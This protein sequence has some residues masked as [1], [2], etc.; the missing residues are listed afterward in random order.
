MSEFW[1]SFYGPTPTG[2][3]GSSFWDTFYGD[4]EEESEEEKRYKERIRRMAESA[5]PPEPRDPIA[6]LNQYTTEKAY[7]GARESLEPHPEAHFPDFKEPEE[8]SRPDYAPELGPTFLTNSEGPV[9]QLGQAMQ[10]AWSEVSQKLQQHQQQAMAPEPRMAQMTQPPIE[11]EVSSTALGPDQFRLKDY[12]RGQT[13]LEQYGEVPEGRVTHG[14]S[15]SDPFYRDPQSLGFAGHAI[16]AANVELIRTLEGIT[17]I[18]TRMVEVG[19]AWGK[20]SLEEA[21]QGNF[22]TTEPGKAAWA[23]L[24]REGSTNPVS[25]WFDWFGTAVQEAFPE[26]EVGSEIA[27][28]MVGMMGMIGAEYAFGGGFIRRA[29]GIG[30]KA[31]VTKEFTTVMR[32]LK[33]HPKLATAAVKASNT[34][35]LA[36]RRVGANLA[37][38]G[39]LDL[40]QVWTGDAS[41]PHLIDMIGEDKVPGIM[42]TMN[43][44]AGGRAL[45]EL[46]LGAVA[47]GIIEPIGAFRVVGKEGAAFAKATPGA[48]SLARQHDIPLRDLETTMRKQRAEAVEAVASDNLKAHPATAKADADIDDLLLTMQHLNLDKH[49]VLEYLA[50]GL[51]GRQKIGRKDVEQ[52]YETLVRESGTTVK[53]GKADLRTRLSQVIPQE[54]TVG[55]PQ[56]TRPTVKKALKAREAAEAAKA[57]SARELVAKGQE[58]LQRAG[59]RYMELSREGLGTTRSVGAEMEVFFDPALKRD[60][61]LWGGSLMARAKGAL[62]RTEFDATLR[63]RF[64]SITDNILVQ[65]HKEAQK[66]YEAYLKRNARMKGSTW[67]ELVPG[68]ELTGEARTFTMADEV[69]NADQFGTLAEEAVAKGIKVGGHRWYQEGLLPWLTNVMGSEDEARLFLAMYSASS[70]GQS[71]GGGNITVAAQAMARFKAGQVIYDPAEKIFLGYRGASVANTLGKVIDAFRLAKDPGSGINSIKYRNFYEALTGK[72]R[73]VVDIWMQRIYGYDYWKSPKKVQLDR[74]TGL[75]KTEKVSPS[76]TPKQYE[77]VA[78]DVDR[79]AWEMRPG[80]KL[81]D[82]GRMMG[83][84]G[85]EGAPRSAVQAAIWVGA[86]IMKQGKASDNAMPA[87]ELLARRLDDLIALRGGDEYALKNVAKT[88][89]A[90]AGAANYGAL[91]YMSNATAGA[92]LGLGTG[93]TW[94]ERL[95]NSLKLGLG[96]AMGT[97]IAGRWTRMLR[98]SGGLKDAIALLWKS[99]TPPVKISVAVEPGIRIPP[100]G[101]EAKQ[102][103]RLRATHNVVVDAV[104]DLSDLFGLKN[105][106]QVNARTRSAKAIREGGLE[107]GGD[108]EVGMNIVM[109][110]DATPAHVRAVMSL[111]SDLTDQRGGFNYQLNEQ[112]TG[113]VVLIDFRTKP[114]SAEIKELGRTIKE[115]S[116]GRGHG[117]EYLGFSLDGKQMASVNGTEHISAEEFLDI[118]DEAADLYSGSKPYRKRVT[119]VEDMRADYDFVEPK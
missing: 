5:K 103:T 105:L 56:I 59:K 75:F 8:L 116:R 83:D 79:I 52:L 31:E 100:T 117:D 12:P 119:H 99:P 24:T 86:Q 80:G 40:G 64:P 71:A 89:W 14:D 35:R 74:E 93:D 43:K 77:F 32:W 1:D 25:E 110:E 68:G 114:T 58:A 10:V 33:G 97:H 41:L 112:A 108:F 20:A 30:K 4:D 92:L 104:H 90:E 72:D 3:T 78:A 36:T 22:L 115:I 26:P 73:T 16:G 85:D 67:S 109:P 111:V 107:L 2:P 84:V 94:E 17:D 87:V 23:A 15:E 9:E 39:P 6:S 27:G 7:A 65:S 19:R 54:P 113:Q 66:V 37:S 51:T 106:P 57:G 96:G 21:K 69:I 44:N 42:N 91:A 13:F 11:A 61:G 28:S 88:G 76:F 60:M 62:E 38:Y 34:G 45:F 53:P 55:L 46:I 102:V 82:L 81:E 98:K 47:D 95:K 118:L 101:S 48:A 63:A 49:K 70:S 29:F 18:P 50:D